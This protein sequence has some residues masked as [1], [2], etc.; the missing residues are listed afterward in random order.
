MSNI[1]R[2]QTPENEF[3]VLI[4][5]SKI[6]D[7]K[8]LEITSYNFMVIG[9]V[10]K[11]VSLLIFQQLTN[12]IDALASPL[13]NNIIFDKR[14]GYTTNEVL[15]TL[16]SWG[17]RGRI[18]YLIIEFW[19]MTFYFS[20]Y[21]AAFI[22]IIN[23][24]CNRIIKNNNYLTETNK[25]YLKRFGHFPQILVLVD[26]ME[27]IFQIAITLI[28]HFDISISPSYFS[29]LVFIGSVFN[30]IKWTLVPMGMITLLLLFCW[31]IISKFITFHNTYKDMKNKKQ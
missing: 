18:Y 1:Q 6:I 12:L 29:A 26:T 14:Y 8:V 23:R 31:V 19:D 30:Q 9:I 3:L 28:Y 17:S 4:K 27:D 22:V 24:T 25:K 7:D 13:V 2:K 21:C 15:Q 16:Q 20:S 11:I 10:M 5:Q